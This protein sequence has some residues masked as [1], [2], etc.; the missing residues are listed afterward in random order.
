MNAKIESIGRISHG[1][2]GSDEYVRIRTEEACIP[3]VVK[4][5]LLRQVYR[6]T[7]QEAGGYFCHRV[8]VMGP[9]PYMED[10]FVAIIHHQYDV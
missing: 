9:H 4:D 1:V 5:W 2:E 6:D 8:T 7:T 3:S 10:E